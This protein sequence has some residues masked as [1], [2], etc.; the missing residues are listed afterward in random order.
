MQCQAKTADGRQCGAN[1]LHNSSTCLLHS[2]AASELGRKG[3]SHRTTVLSLKKLARPTSALAVRRLLSQTLI[4]LREG[5]L[6]ARRGR[7]I[8][9][10][11]TALLR[12]I[13]ISDHEVRIR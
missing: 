1:A 4:E 10:G 3:G 2:G 6:D 7:A 11:A 12:A 9:T 5:S 8:L 13:K